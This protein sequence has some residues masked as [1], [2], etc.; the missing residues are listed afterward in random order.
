MEEADRRS[1]LRHLAQRYD[2]LMRRLV[3]RL[4]VVE[5][6]DALQDA[7]LRI[8][9]AEAV[10]AVN[11]PSAY[12]LRVAKNAAADRR[13][14]FRRQRLDDVEVA[15]LMEIEDNTPSPAA[16]LESREELDRLSA[17]LSELP[18]RR[19]AIFLAARVEELPHQFIAA[20]FGVSVRT[21]ANEID[22]TLEHCG[23]RLKK[24][25]NKVAD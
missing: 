16:I 24:N 8:G 14:T 21:V 15:R 1:L 4:G 7:Y 9:Q 10:P 5:A 20:R 2:E 18:E 17:A 6:E 19:R 3:P 11:D 12:L 13:R 25:R 22:R 23:Q